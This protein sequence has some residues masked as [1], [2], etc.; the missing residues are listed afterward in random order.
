VETSFI[1]FEGVTD[2]MQNLASSPMTRRRLL[3]GAGYV[4]GG[5]LVLGMAARSGFAFQANSA[6]TGPAASSSGMLNQARMQAASAPVKTTRLNDTLFLLQCAGGNQIAQIGQDGKLLIDSSFSTAAPHVIE[7]VGKLDA[8]PIKL[9]VNTHWHFDHTDG[10]AAMHDAGAFIIAHR[11]TRTRLSTP[12]DIAA[13]HLH[14]D[15]SPASGLPQ[16]TFESSQSIYFNNDEVSMAYIDPAHTDT[17]IYVFFK[18]GN[19][20]HAGDIWFN[21]F[22]P[23]IDASSGGRAHGMIKGVEQLLAIADD[24]TKIVPGHGPLGDKAQLQ[25]YRDMLAGVTANV[26]KLK[27]SGQTVEQVV[28]AKPTAAFDAVW[29]KG[30]LDPDVFTTV[31]Y[32]TLT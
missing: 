12:Q 2:L 1:Y 17:D 6:T 26:E 27:S 9:L 15:P 31:V 20:L 28:A 14:L 21:G 5:N 4:L 3:R 11:N 8:H 18:N 32:N 24:R 30:S 29:A 10:N 19:V 22:Y 7:A 16:Q 13:Y 25:K 23:F